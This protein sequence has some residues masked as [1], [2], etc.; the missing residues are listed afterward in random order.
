M[1]SREKRACPKVFLSRQYARK[2]VASSQIARAARLSSP[3]N[4]SEVTRHSPPGCVSNAV[5]QV[6]APPGMRFTNK[7]SHRSSA[8]KKFFGIALLLALSMMGLGC[9]SSNYAPSQ[10][11]NAQGSVYVTGEDA[12]ASSVVGF[13]VTID[14]LTLNNGSTT[15][16]RF[17][18]PRRLILR[19][20]SVCELCSA[21]TLF[22]RAA[23]TA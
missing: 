12:P 8:M 14:S 3:G 15:V 10:K 13:N 4:L 19:G 9:G 1:V 22:R 11:S 17:R 23:T 6:A 2:L 5:K 20:C 16:V 18:R 21:S 7:L